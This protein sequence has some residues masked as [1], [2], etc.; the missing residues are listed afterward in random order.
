MITLTLDD[1][2]NVIRDVVRTE[3]QNHRNKEPPK[4]QS[5]FITRQQAAKILQI[6]LP[7]LLEYTKRGLIPMYRISTKVR[8]IKQEVEE[9]V[10]RI[11]TINN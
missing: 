1:F 11:K 3:F 8:Y 7:T 2:Q 4:T 6:S 10:K 5:E 9:S